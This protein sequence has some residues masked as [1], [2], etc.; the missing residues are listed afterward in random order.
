[1]YLS[2]AISMKLLCTEC[3]Y[4]RLESESTMEQTNHQPIAFMNMFRVLFLS[5]TVDTPLSIFEEQKKK[6]LKEIMNK[7]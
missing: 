3:V 6:K 1:M 4:A 2:D 5:E 7:N